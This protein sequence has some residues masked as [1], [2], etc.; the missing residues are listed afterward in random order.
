MSTIRPG[1]V[2]ARGR[3]QATIVVVLLLALLPLQGTLVAAT[4]HPA[5]RTWATLFIAVVVQAM[6][7][8][9]GGVL[10]AATISTLVSE[11]FI[12]R[13]LPR[14]PVLAVPAAGIA[15]AALPG[16]ECGSVPVGRGLMERGVAP[17]VALAFVLASPAINPVV[18]VTTAVAFPGRPEMVLARFLASLAVAVAVGWLWTLMRGEVP[19]RSRGH[20]HEG[21]RLAQFLGSAR[22]DL[23]H[24]GGFL[25][26]GAVIAATVNTFLPTRWLDALAGSFTVSVLALA[27]FAYLVAVCSEAD[28]FVAASMAAFSPVAQLAFMVVGPAMDVKLTALHAGTFGNRFALG[29]VPL[30]LGCA[31]AASLAVGGWL[32]L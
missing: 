20:H 14:N 26:A 1:T 7:F 8:L 18:L 3:H 12:R 24:A 31:L 30:V 21:G 13:V 16:C 9:V 6:P 5:L 17:G 23:L 15:G 10:L 11:R 19:L 22:H 32:L 4:D 27:A 28:A 29:F 25:V 2:T